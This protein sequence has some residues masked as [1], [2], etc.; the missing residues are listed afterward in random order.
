VGIAHKGTHGF[1][2]GEIVDLYTTWQWPT[3]CEVIGCLPAV[4]E[5]GTSDAPSTL[6]PA[7]DAVKVVEAV[8]IEQPAVRPVQTIL[9][10]FRGQVSMRTR[11]KNTNK[12]R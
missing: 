11:P 12:T 2:R 8:G 5:L 4:D 3:L 1:R 10:W 6:H 7:N 9:E